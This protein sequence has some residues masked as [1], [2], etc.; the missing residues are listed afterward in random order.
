MTATFFLSEQNEL[1][2]EIEAKTDKATVVNLTNHTYLNLAGGGRCDH[3]GSP[4]NPAFNSL[5]VATDNSGI[6]TGI[7]R[8]IST[9]LISEGRLK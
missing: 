9:P 5:C 4:V 7:E 8:V 3:P 1:R 6:P 2:I